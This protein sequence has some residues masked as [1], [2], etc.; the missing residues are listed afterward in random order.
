M[1][2]CEF[3]YWYSTVLTGGVCPLFKKISGFKEADLALS[4]SAEILS[5]KF[6][7]YQVIIN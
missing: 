2:Q 1:K 7:L 5:E 6:V 3:K 4:H